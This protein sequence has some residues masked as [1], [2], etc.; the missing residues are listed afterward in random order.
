MKFI[1]LWRAFADQ[2]LNNKLWGPLRLLSPQGW[3]KLLQLVGF[4]A[5]SVVLFQNC[6]RMRFDAVELS[7]VPPLGKLS[8]A[9]QINSGDAFTS[10]SKVSLGLTSE[11]ASE[12]YITNDPNCLQGGYWQVFTPVKSWDLTGL[13][14]E[15]F[16]YA[17]FSASGVES[18]CVSASII[19]DDVPP[20][21]TVMGKPNPYSNIAT[22]A[23]K[24]NAQDGAGSGVLSRL[25]KVPGLPDVN[26]NSE[27]LVDKSGANIGLADCSVIDQKLLDG[28]RQFQLVA[29]DKAGNSSQETVSWILDRVPPMITVS[30]NQAAVTASTNIL[31]SFSAT[32]A[33]SPINRIECSIDSVTLANCAA[34]QNFT[35]LAAGPHTLRYLAV[36]EAGN[37]S[38]V[39]TYSWTIDLSAP[40]V[41][42][43]NPLP[44][45]FSKLTSVSFNFDGTDSGTPITN[46]RCKLDAQPEFVCVSGVTVTVTEGAH[47]FSVV[48]FDSVNNKSAPA[49]HSW[50]TDLTKPVVSI[51]SKPDFETRSDSA[52]FTLQVTE[53]V[54]SVATLRC[55]L[56][57]G[58]WID[59]LSLTAS[60]SGLA[61]GMHVFEVEAIDGA[62]NSSSTVNGS[63][64]TVYDSYTWYRDNS[65]PVLTVTPNIAALTK[66]T[67]ANFNLSAVAGRGRSVVFECK[68]PDNPSWQACAS[69]VAMSAP[70]DREY[71][72]YFRAID[73]IGNISAQQTFAWRVDNA[74]P[75]ISFPVS[76]PA[77]GDNATAYSIQASVSDAYANPSSCNFVFQK[78]GGTVSSGACASRVNQNL[79]VMVVGN[80]KFTVTGVDALGNSSSASYDWKISNAGVAQSKVIVGGD[81][82]LDVLIVVDNS[83]S[84]NYEISST[85]AYLSSFLSKLAG[86]NWRLAI[87]TTQVNTAD[88]A[89]RLRNFTA[90]GING[91]YIDSSMDAT[92]RQAA[93]NVVL[94][95][96]AAETATPGAATGYEQGI[97]ASTRAL[98]R[99]SVGM[100]IENYF[101]ELKLHLTAQVATLRSSVGVFPSQVTAINNALS[102]GNVNYL[103][104]TM[105]DYRLGQ[106]IVFPKSDLKDQTVVSDLQLLRSNF[107][108]SK[109]AYDQCVA[110]TGQLNTAQTN[111]GVT[112]EAALKAVEAE[113]ALAAPIEITEF[114]A[115]VTKLIGLISSL[116]TQTEAFSSAVKASLDLAA[117]ECAKMGANRSQTLSS[118]QFLNS[119]ITSNPLGVSTVMSIIISNIL[120]QYGF[121]ASPLSSWHTT[122]ALTATQNVA[123]SLNSMLNTSNGFSGI[124][125][126]IQNYMSPLLTWD[127]TLDPSLQF[128]RSEAVFSIIVVSDAD[129]SPDPANP[130]LDLPARKKLLKDS[131]KNT[132]GN[133]KGFI[134][135]AMIVP[136]PDTNNCQAA[137][138]AGNEAPGV[139][140]TELVNETGGYA[141]SVCGL[142]A[143]WDR[144][145]GL[146]GQRSADMT[147][148]TFI[149]N[150]VPMDQDLNPVTLDVLVTM[151]TVP[152]T[153]GWSVTGDTINFDLP[154][155]TGKVVKIDYKCPQ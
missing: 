11:R 40:T 144:D 147:K 44:S 139:L 6:N 119:K 69:G 136:S 31:F 98:Q 142:A 12:V 43:R 145:L 138:G 114:R 109:A 121:S 137:V 25:I 149:L 131:V 151:D 16:V 7:S 34:T 83:F 110:L 32:D 51:T 103:T 89:G 38:A 60:F 99:L 117:I 28:P 81:N 82:K 9:I 37:K 10:H 111:S 90:V 59:C 50:T 70:V 133:T 20:T 100:T 122:Q 71:I 123:S 55:R 102:S 29:V 105:I 4:F 153:S 27:M 8:G 49:T 36:D 66:A 134:F 95:G 64:V 67:T 45:A 33:V 72:A 97:Q 15:V 87:T 79:G 86:L 132:L 56:N 76:P 58:A 104:N 150:C 127:P 93:Y 128:F 135:N 125:T 3:A 96:I 63:G 13:N 68:Y 126:G 124:I 101:N 17:K 5:V 73:S 46:F 78:D 65:L 91:P 116:K 18:E 35:S 84:M 85:K 154:V 62:G 80:Y 94:D 106:G 1:G 75:A 146:I 130:G 14:T 120:T 118:L 23:L 54:S 115:K 140:Y 88:I 53:A 47:T 30:A 24:F 57:A 74:G 2:V 152:M 61:D 108:S 113:L 48:G 141:G 143:D 107:A 129:E 92:Q 19:H 77:V 26:C 112:V 148:K 22:S 21:L 42:L 155:P 41:T 39:A 52:N